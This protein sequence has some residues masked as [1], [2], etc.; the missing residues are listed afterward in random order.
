MWQVQIKNKNVKNWRWGNIYK[1]LGSKCTIKVQGD[2]WQWENKRVKPSVNSKLIRV[3]YDS[4]QRERYALKDWDHLRILACGANWA[5]HHNLPFL[6]LLP[7]IN[8]NIK[9]IS[10]KTKARWK[11]NDRMFCSVCYASW[12]PEVIPVPRKMCFTKRPL[13]QNSEDLFSQLII[14]AQKSRAHWS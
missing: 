7:E 3:R 9:K 4:N 12:D 6:I 1:C 13:S 2:K 14:V 5:K 11:W 8:L 10:R